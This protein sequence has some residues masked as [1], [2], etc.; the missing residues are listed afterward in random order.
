MAEGSA[1]EPII[2]ISSSR[3]AQATRDRLVEALERDGYEPFF[4]REVRPGDEWAAELHEART[5]ADG[6]VVIVSP[7]ALQSAWILQEVTEFLARDAAERGFRLV[8]LPVEGVTVEDIYRSPL[9]ALGRLQ[10][11]TGKTEADRIAQVLTGLSPLKSVE[12]SVVERT[13]PAEAPARRGNVRLAVVSVNADVVR[14]WDAARG[15][16]LR[17][18]GYS[19]PVVALATAEVGRRSVVASGHDDGA[20]RLV[21]AETGTDVGTL[22]GHEGPVAAVDAVPFP[23]EPMLVVGGEDGA[24]T[25]WDL[26]LLAKLHT[27]R[28]HEDGVVSLAAVV[29]DGRVVVASFGRDG[30]VRTWDANTGEAL[31]AH[32]ATGDFRVVAAGE[33]AAG[34]PI[35]ALG[36]DTG[37]VEIREAESGDR[38][39]LIPCEGGIHALRI[40]HLDGRPV[41]VASEDDQIRTFDLEAERELEPIRGFDVSVSSLAVGDVAGRAIVVSG[42]GHGVIRVHDAVTRAELWRTPLSADDAPVGRAHVALAALPRAAYDHVEWLTDAPAADDLLKR[43]PLAR[44]LA[45][46]LRHIHTAART[47]H[48]SFLVHVDGPWGS[49]KSTLLE[50]LQQELANDWLIVP[51]DA[52]RQ[53]R[54]GPPWWAL[55]TRLR[56]DL[57]HGLSRRERLRLRFAEVVERIRRAGAP[58]VLALV[59]LVVAALGLFVLLRPSD[60]DGTAAG[61]I[62][63][64][65]SAVAA[66]LATLWAGAFVVSRFLLWDSATGARL[67]EQSHQNPMESLAA[68]FAWLLERAGKPVVFFIDD[69]DRCTEEYV[70][71]LLESVQTLIRDAPRRFA[72]KSRSSAPYFVVAADGAWLRRGFEQA[73]AN[74][75]EAVGQPGRPLGYLF[76]DKIFQLTVP[77]PAISLTAQES[78]LSDLLALEEPDSDEFAAEKA[79]VEERV[80][81]STSRGE[82]VDALRKASPQVRKEV[83][84]SLVEKLNES[85]V[86]QET[87]HE[88]TKF[89][90]LLEPNPREI[91]RFLNTFAIADSILVLQDV[92]VDR[93]TLALWTIL[94]VRWPALGDY[95]R[96]NPDAV[97]SLRAAGAAPDGVGDDLAPLFDG[98]EA[99]IVVACPEGGP[100]TPDLVRRC[101][102]F[103]VG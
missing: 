40:A 85:A 79:A 87:E 6:A 4:D 38:I 94:R 77:V 67:F 7:G 99:S 86:V 23:E 26:E 73:Y 39:K 22:T 70:V 19:S 45:T 88:L 53:S 74:F 69:L 16:L 42:D 12:P 13:T 100:L 15:R 37:A 93:D 91:I 89:A 56:H 9:N 33:R 80:R 58:Y 10:V 25:T 76:L 1:R 54:V 71:E 31:A 11:P 17:T 102:G 98:S 66:A 3:D 21:D 68:H 81:A 43:R 2:F 101:C 34:R 95:L 24:I 92:F 78:Y 14:I 83:A 75:S 103:V 28:A 60:L 63:K 65:V 47:K 72:R 32:K 50:F 55:L 52:W 84:P 41:L 61:D 62:A 57:A 90:P 36:G 27:L 8:S 20:V 35:V 82:A 59:L 49:G 48:T 97:D 51:F 64:A 5:T 29:A 18:Y 30:Y 44:A 46:R 96:R